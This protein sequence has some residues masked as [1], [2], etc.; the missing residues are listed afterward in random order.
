MNKAVELMVQ[1]KGDKSNFFK[2]LYII[3]KYGL[4]LDKKA[5]KTMIKYSFFKK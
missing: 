1:D 2:S 5:I 4:V 3:K